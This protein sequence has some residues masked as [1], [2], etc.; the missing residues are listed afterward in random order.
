MSKEGERFKQEL[1]ALNN[2]DATEELNQAL[3]EMGTPKQVLRKSQ[4]ESERDEQK[5]QHIFIKKEERRDISA[6]TES[7]DEDFNSIIEDIHD[8]IA[9]CGIANYRTLGS[10]IEDLTD[11]FE[12]ATLTETAS[13]SS[14]FYKKPDL[15]GSF[16]VQMKYIIADGIV[17]PT[18]SFAKILEVLNEREKEH[19][20]LAERAE[21]LV[22]RDVERE[23]L[24]QLMDLCRSI[25]EAPRDVIKNIKSERFKSAKDQNIDY[26]RLIWTIIPGNNRVAINRIVNQLKMISRASVEQKGEKIVFTAPFEK[27]F[28]DEAEDS[29]KWISGSWL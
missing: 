16:V 23:S 15:V 1:S 18:M 28:L 26:D 29:F 4:L 11:A 5:E 7:D 9:E 13:K 8:L 2:S 22:R 14:R 27:R 12:V 6:A 20:E 25:D 10:V 3:N 19:Q 17:M 24:R 21:E